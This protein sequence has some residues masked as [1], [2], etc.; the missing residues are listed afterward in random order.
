[1]KAWRNYGQKAGPKRS[2]QS[3]V[4]VARVIAPY[5]HQLSDHDS[6]VWLQTFRILQ[7]MNQEEEATYVC[8]FLLALA[9]CNAPPSSLDLL[10]ESFERVHEAVRIGRL[11]DR[12][13]II[14]EPLVPHL[15]WLRDWDKCE[16]LR[17][18]LILAFF[19]NQ[20][21]AAELNRRIEDRDLIRQ[22]L[23]SAE[24]VDGGEEF[25]RGVA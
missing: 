9:F 5:A 25:F 24:D 13:W 11:S 19:S 6:T 1:M 15:S 21:P 23:K 10:S 14:V 12:E 4:A 16:R 22:I 17:R 2:T 8:T 18:G 3:L 20:W 7:D